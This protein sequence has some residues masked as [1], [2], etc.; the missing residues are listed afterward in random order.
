MTKF[1]LNLNSRE[2]KNG[3]PPLHMACIAGNTKLAKYLIDVR[4]CVCISVMSFE[5]YEVLLLV[6][7]PTHTLSHTLSHTHTHSLTNIY[8]HR[9]APKW[10]TFP[11]NLPHERTK[12]L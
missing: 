8:T 1:G 12:P 3:I 10:S 4:M 11:S 6:Y 2:A 9:W 7:T 5:C